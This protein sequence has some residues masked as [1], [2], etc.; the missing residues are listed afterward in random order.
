MSQLEFVLLCESH[1]TSC[2]TFIGFCGC[3]FSLNEI[4][5]IAWCRC[6]GTEEDHIYW[7]N[8]LYRYTEGE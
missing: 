7:I 2:D 6:D 4:C 3:P 5:Y 8:E 1:N